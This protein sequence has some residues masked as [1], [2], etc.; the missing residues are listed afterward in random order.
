[1]SPRPNSWSGVGEA[2][3]ASYA[4]LCAGT[5]A[6]LRELLGAG[7]GRTLLDVGAGT[8]D[9]AASF[10]TDGWIVDPREPEASMRAV[11]RQRHPE[12]RI[13]EGALPRLP[14]ADGAF[15]AVVANFVLNH[16]PDPRA[17]AAELRRVTRDAAA[18]TIWIRSPSWLW[19]EVCERAG[20]QAAPGGRLPEDKDFE[21][22]ADGFARMLQDGGWHAP[23]VVEKQWIW[24]APATALW[25][26]VEGGVAGAGAYYL[27]LDAPDRARFRSAFD[28]LIVERASDGVLALEHV[29]AVAVMRRDPS[30]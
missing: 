28:A 1:M 6:T 25:A 17:A 3:A 18:A 5:G 11:A 9:L 19:A 22:T 27:G 16:V 7:D 15:D 2:Y 23:D 26:S 10:V 8:G 4:E 29:A 12:I 13:T 14:D 30:L 21:R 24:N 20:L